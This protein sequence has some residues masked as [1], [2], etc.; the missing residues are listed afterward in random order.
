[1]SNN[2][3]DKLDPD[4][5]DLQNNSFEKLIDKYDQTI[6]EFKRTLEKFTETIDSGVSQK[7]NDYIEI[8][9]EK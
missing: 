6:T 9:E 1:M 4:G 3:F 2:D 8:T 7:E 5:H